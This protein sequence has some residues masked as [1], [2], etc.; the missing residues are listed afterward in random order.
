MCG[1]YRREGKV[2]AAL[3]RGLE[4]R[5]ECWWSAVVGADEEGS[6]GC[7]CERDQLNA[8]VR[9]GGVVAGLKGQSRELSHYWH[10]LSSGTEARRGRERCLRGGSGGGAGGGQGC[11]EGKG[12][13]RVQ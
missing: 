9:S 3:Q 10:S 1:G 6:V 11:E 8:E 2:A 12:K 5:K 13:D 7:V 4:G